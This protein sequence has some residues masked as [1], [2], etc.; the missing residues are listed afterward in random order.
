MALHLPHHSSRLRASSRARGGEKK[1]GRRSVLGTPHNQPPRA[2]REFRMGDRWFLIV[3]AFLRVVSFL[4]RA[5]D[6]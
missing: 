6:N 3:G 4:A 5:R 1:E 2:K